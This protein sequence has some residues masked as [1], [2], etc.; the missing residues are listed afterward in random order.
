M[1]IISNSEGNFK[2]S[3]NEIFL[4][5]LPNPNSIYIKKSEIENVKKSNPNFF[6]FL[7]QQRTSTRRDKNRARNRKRLIKCFI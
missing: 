7:E 3:D 6:N 1:N 4:L 5:K 2:I